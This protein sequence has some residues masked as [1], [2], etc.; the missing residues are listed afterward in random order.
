MVISTSGL[1]GRWDLKDMQKGD[2]ALTVEE[3][4]S[5]AIQLRLGGPVLLAD[6]AD[7]GKASGYFDAQI[8][9]YLTY[10]IKKDAFNRF[11]L[12]ALGSFQEKRGDSRDRKQAL[13]TLGIAME[14]T[15]GASAAERI[16]PRG[17][18]LISGSSASLED[19]FHEAPGAIFPPG[20]SKIQ[21][22]R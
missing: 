5:D 8:L 20:S 22:K 18:R 9:G 10:D 17:T 12:V 1:S 19:Y 11:D 13:V 3:V 21:T 4:T 15:E 16:P 6:A 2:L 14:M 7:L